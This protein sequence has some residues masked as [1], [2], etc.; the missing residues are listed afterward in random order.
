MYSLVTLRRKACRIG[1]VIH[2]GYQ[3]YLSGNAIVRD[4]EGNPITGYCLVDLTDHT[5]VWGSYNEVFCYLYDL[6]DV[7]DFLKLRYAEENLKF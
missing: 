6:R 5:L 1:Y 2:K 4:E 7:E 3:R